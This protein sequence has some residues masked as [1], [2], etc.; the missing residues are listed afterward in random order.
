MVDHRLAGQRE[1]RLRNV[2]RQ[3]PE[4][5][6]FKK[7]KKIHQ[8]KREES[9]I[10]DHIICLKKAYLLWVRRPRSRR[11]PSLES[12]PWF[13]L[14]PLL[15]KSLRSIKPR[16]R[17]AGELRR[18][19]QGGRKKPTVSGK[20]KGGE[21]ATGEKYFFSSKQTMGKQKTRVLTAGSGGWSGGWRLYG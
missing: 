9:G 20:R 10:I 7:T 13:P 1:E 6:T 18:R 12:S 17:Q 21:E 3:R 19:E 16:P 8:R 14:P 15:E 4:P 5:S 11:P 2:Q